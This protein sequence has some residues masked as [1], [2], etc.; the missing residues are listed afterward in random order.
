MPNMFRLKPLDSLRQ[1]LNLHNDAQLQRS[2]SLMVF[3]RPVLFCP[4][5]ALL[6]C[7][8]P[9][10]STSSILFFSFSFSFFISPVGSQLLGLP[11]TAFLS[12][13]CFRLFNDKRTL[14]GSFD[15]SLP[16]SQQSVVVVSQFSSCSVW[17]CMFVLMVFYVLYSVYTTLTHSQS[18]PL[19]YQFLEKNISLAGQWHSFRPLSFPAGSSWPRK[20]SLATRLTIIILSAR[21]LNPVNINIATSSSAFGCLCRQRA[22]RGWKRRDERRENYI[23]RTGL[24][25]HINFKPCGQCGRILCKHASARREVKADK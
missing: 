23:T 17:H 18:T 11:A 25:A 3:S 24:A 2:C 21:Q 13:L 5:S 9:L 20:G 7:L 19:L 12:S 16:Q 10:L 8:S 22:A 15:S 4:H 6:F 14:S 1:R